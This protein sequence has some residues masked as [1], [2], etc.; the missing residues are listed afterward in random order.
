M[1]AHFRL[2]PDGMVRIRSDVPGGRLWA[3]WESLPATPSPYLLLPM[4]HPLP[5]AQ[6]PRVK[7]ADGAWHEG[8]LAAAREAGAQDALL[9]WPDGSVAESAIAAVVLEREGGLW[10]PPAGGRVASLAEALDLPDWIRDRRLSV[11]V[12][13]FDLA[14][15][16]EGTLWCLNAVR[17]MWQAESIAPFPPMDRMR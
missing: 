1:Q 3:T 2:A 17:G 6:E 12:R 14:A 5:P 9:L 11:E 10:I 13:P 4:S 16:R 8:V 7:G 15:V